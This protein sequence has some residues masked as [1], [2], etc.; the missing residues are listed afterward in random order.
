MPLV[1]NIILPLK[2]IIIIFSCISTLFYH[3]TL[4]NV[5]ISVILFFTIRIGDITSHNTYQWYHDDLDA[6][7]PSIF[8]LMLEKQAFE[9][10]SINGKPFCSTYRWYYDNLDAM[11]LSIFLTDDYGRTD[12][13]RNKFLRAKIIFK[14]IFV[15]FTLI[16]FWQDSVSVKHG[17]IFLGLPIY[18]KNIPN[19]QT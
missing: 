16:I 14:G 18:Y 1:P 4:C 8:L 12:L 9:R 13:V 6:M 15:K 2:R 3:I 5:D 11:F 10:V 17:K 7:F 19:Q